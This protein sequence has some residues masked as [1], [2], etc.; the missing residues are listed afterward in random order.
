MRLLSY[1]DLEAKGIRYSRV[2]IWRLVR[3]GKFPPPF[4]WS[5]GDGVRNQW[6]EEEIDALMASRMASRRRAAG[7]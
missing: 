1:E 5:E 6:V 3:A 4:K 2:H 7:I